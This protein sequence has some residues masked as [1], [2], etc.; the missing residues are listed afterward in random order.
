MSWRSSII[1]T[2]LVTALL[3]VLPGG[4]WSTSGGGVRW[5]WGFPHWFVQVQGDT[6]Y[7]YDGFVK[8]NWMAIVVNAIFAALPLGILL[9]IRLRWKMIRPGL[10]YGILVLILFGIYVASIRRIIGP[11]FPWNHGA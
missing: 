3:C 4:Y 10:A 8:Y 2:V 6:P 1:K 7:D 5:R 9:L 11:F